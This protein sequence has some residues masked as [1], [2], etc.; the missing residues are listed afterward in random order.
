MAD[1]QRRIFI[2]RSPER[3][4]HERFPRQRFHGRHHVPVGDTGAPEPEHQARLAVI[5]V[6]YFGPLLAPGK[7]DFNRRIMGRWVRSKHSGV[8]D[9]LPSSMAARSEPFA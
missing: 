1:G 3:V 2:G 6:H 7:R 4:R 9:T 5:E 8:T